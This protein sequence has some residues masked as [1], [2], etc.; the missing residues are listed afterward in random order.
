MSAK[1]KPGR[2]SYQ[3]ACYHDGGMITDGVLL[4]AVAQDRFWMAQADGDLFSWYKAHAEALDVS[5]HDPNVWVSQIQGPRS[6]ELLA[7]VLGW[8]NA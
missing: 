8:T 5:I 2:C 1:V 3:F 6:L 7:A 4:A